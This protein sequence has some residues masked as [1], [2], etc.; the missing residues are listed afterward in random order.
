[1]VEAGYPRY[2]TAVLERVEPSYMLSTS[3]ATPSAELP[4]RRLAYSAEIRHRANYIQPDEEVVNAYERHGSVRRV[5]EELKGVEGL[6]S[7]KEGV[8]SALRAE[9][10]VQA[11][12]SGER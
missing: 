2:T 12:P 3:G 11:V 4:Q 9:G 7:A 5:E 6:Q 1:V 8:R 10:R